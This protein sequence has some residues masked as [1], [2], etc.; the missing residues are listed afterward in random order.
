MMSGLGVGRGL[1][2]RG[3]FEEIMNGNGCMI[4][5]ADSSGLKVCSSY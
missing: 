4:L 2:G 5:G 3:W 1:L